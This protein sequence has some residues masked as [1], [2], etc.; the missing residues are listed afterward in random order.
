PLVG[1]E[2]YPT[3][4]IVFS[5]VVLLVIVWW[6]MWSYQAYSVSTE[7]NSVADKLLFAIV[8]TLSTLL[9]YVVMSYVLERAIS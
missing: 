7:R 1:F 9:S 3:F 4:S 8:A 6:L 2:L 5:I